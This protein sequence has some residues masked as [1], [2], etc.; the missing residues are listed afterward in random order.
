M[1]FKAKSLYYNV[2]ENLFSTLKVTIKKLTSNLSGTY[3]KPIC[4]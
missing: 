4:T 1:T 2:N 3:E